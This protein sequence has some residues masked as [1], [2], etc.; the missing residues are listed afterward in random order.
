MRETMYGWMTLH[1]K[2]EGKGDPIAEPEHRLD[3]PEDLACYPDPT[4]RPKGFLT[5]PLYA[6]KVGRELVANVDKLVPDHKEMWEATAIGMRAQLKT[7]LGSIAIAKEP[8]IVFG[9]LNGD[10]VLTSGTVKIEIDDG[11]ELSCI[12]THPSLKEDFRSGALVL[13]PQGAIQPTNENKVREKLG[14][15]EYSLSVNL[16]ATGPQQP[17]SGAIAGAPDHTPAEHGIWIGRP[18]LG[19]W[20]VEALSA[21]RV[22]RERVGKE[23]PLV[24]F[25]TGFTAPVAILAAA[26]SSDEHLSVVVEDMMATYVT[27]HP[28]AS[29]T[30]MG[31]LAPGMLKVG[32]IPHLAGMVAPRQLVIAGGVSPQGKKLAQKELDEAF[33]FTA[34][35]YKAHKAADWLTV[36]AEPDWAKIE[37]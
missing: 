10:A 9:A 12:V 14:K 4:D 11:F 6:G 31:I 21:L 24:V 2:G 18:L 8:K 22:L 20:V 37:L 30:P 33:K 13:H 32:D 29:G 35:V 26:Y 36:T 23:K 25:G 27:D 19:Q 3:K 34:S 15:S 5:P 16:R 28:Y 1:L 17:K 7:V